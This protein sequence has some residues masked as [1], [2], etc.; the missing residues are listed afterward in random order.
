MRKSSSRAEWLGAAALLTVLFC[1][2]PARAAHAPDTVAALGRQIF[3]D[4]SLS[5]SGRLSCASCHSPTHAYGP[6]DGAA[7]R[8]GGPA[9]DRAEYRAVP[10]LRYTLNHTPKW[11]APYVASAAERL[12]E[13]QEPPAGGFGWDGRFATLQEQ[14]EFALLAANEMA[15]AGPAQ[16]IER[17]AHAPY[18]P[19]FRKVFGAAVFDHPRQAYAQALRA[20]EYFELNDATF[21]PF[22]SKFDAYLD[23]NATL[24]AQERRG[25]VLFEDPARGNCASCHPDRKGADGSHPLFTDY[26]FEAL[27]VP[28]N[29]EIPANANANY[30]DEGLCGPLRTDQKRV[31]GYCGLFRTPTLRNVAARTVFFHNG[32]FHALRTALQFYVQRDT[33]PQRWYPLSAGKPD[34]FDDLP[35]VLRSNVDVSDAPLTRAAG[36]APMWSATDID[37]VMAFLKTLTDRDV[38]TAAP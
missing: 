31:V 19:D 27:G 36:Q 12:L 15:N 23:G 5:S 20:L 9:L 29:P 7:V 4:P 13:G 37:D 6:A 33:H 8:R 18:A 34:K 2:P 16:V 1:G 25:L 24:S 14:A 3:F 32:R 30:F 17:L 38:Q 35:P 28:R 26:Q 10:A 21:H 11:N 22:S